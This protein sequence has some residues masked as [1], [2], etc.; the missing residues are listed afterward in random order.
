MVQVAI[1]YANG[2]LP[3]PNHLKPLTMPLAREN[4]TGKRACIFAWAKDRFV[5][6][7]A[8]RFE[9]DM[10]I[11]IQRRSPM[12]DFNADTH[13]KDLQDRRGGS[14][15]QPVC[16]DELDLDRTLKCLTNPL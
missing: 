6:K 2:S 3:S 5:E 15:W 8:C 4:K 14:A 11:S 10:N 12:T 16:Q 9:R 13:A 1:L 7:I